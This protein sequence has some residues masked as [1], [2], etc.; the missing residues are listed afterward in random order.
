M[1]DQQLAAVVR[2][3]SFYLTALL[4]MLTVGSELPAI[5]GLPGIIPSHLII[6]VGLPLFFTLFVG[7]RR[8]ARPFLRFRA[9]SGTGLVK[10]VV[11]GIVGW[12]TAQVMGA[13]LVLAVQQM[14]G[15]MMQPYD[16]LLSGPAWLAIVTGAV[17]PA[18]SE[19]FS[20]RGYVLG[21]LRSLGPVKAVLITGLLFGALHLSLIRLIPLTL[22]GMLW[23][24]V[25]QRTGSILPGMIMHFL[26]NG[27]ALALAL[28]ARPTPEA[29]TAADIGLP[30]L[31][32]GALAVMGLL[33]VGMA[34]AAYFIARSFSP[35]DLRDPAQAE[36]P[37]AP[38][39]T[40][41]EAA[42]AGQV[43]LT[44]DLQNLLEEGRRI[45]SRRRGLQM[46]VGGFAALLILLI[47]SYFAYRELFLTFY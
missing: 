39:L 46:A 14:G 23:A 27:I 28:S 30:G 4:L 22:L 33:A 20:F 35:R 24:M 44:A 19:E 26:N 11:L 41:V 13:V 8:E 15:K 36:E 1:T 31:S 42:L 12:M 17:L 9:L 6:F 10:S 25:V 5:I 40:P 2:V 18:V 7:V 16:I 47:Y 38:A 45:R 29:A 21:E 3:L 37:F 43:D 32:G 34:V